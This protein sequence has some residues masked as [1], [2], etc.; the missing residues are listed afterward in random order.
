MAEAGLPGFAA[1]SWQG[2]FAPAATPDAIV[3]RLHTEVRAA[4]LSDDIRD[5][6]ASQG[7]IIEATAPADF[8][9]FVAAETRRWAEVVRAGNVS[10][11]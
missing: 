2:L 3:Q 4:M 10:V 1:T 6:F 11:N 5:G 9:S 8:A 7:F